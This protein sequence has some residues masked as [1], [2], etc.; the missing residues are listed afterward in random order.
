M[1]D[2]LGWIG[3]SRQAFHQQLK[4]ADQRTIDVLET[5]QLA[6]KV[7]REHPSMSCRDIYYTAAAEM[8]RGRDWT[9]QVLLSH[10]YRLK[11]KARSFT[12]AGTEV[13]PNLIEGLQVTG[14][15]QVWQT[16][17]TYV[18][19][20][21]R[22]Y[23]V[24]FIVDVFSRHIVAWHCS[25]DL[26]SKA[27]IQCLKKALRNVH[28]SQRRSLIIHTDRGVQYTCAA[29][30]AYVKGRV[31][32]SMA[33]YAWQ[34]AYCERLHR[35]IKENYLRHYNLDSLNALQKGVKKAVTLYNRSKP[36]RGLPGR[37]SPDQFVKEHANGL[38]P[39]Y[40]VNIWSKLTSTK[41]IKMN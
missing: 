10:G 23:Y 40:T 25:G 29:Y 41:M 15:N 34:N 26:S 19:A 20:A 27:Q 14:P 13:C 36:H 33:Y 30:K 37:L 35:T 3:I 7:R 39:E 8:P 38:H 16:D 9:E 11:R 31:H 28:A 6:D 32:H 1:K 24:S 17:I 5:L 2:L 22:W 12:V 4:R 18:W 21:R